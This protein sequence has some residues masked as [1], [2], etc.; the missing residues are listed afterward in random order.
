[1]VAAGVPLSGIDNLRM[2]VLQRAAWRDNPNMLHVLLAAG[3]WSTEV[4][5]SSLA[6]ALRFGNTESVR[7]LRDQGARLDWRD[8]NGET[9]L[10]EAASS[11]VPSLVREILKYHL[12]VNARDSGGWTPL[13]YAVG[14]YH[15]GEEPPPVNRAEVVILLLAAGADPN[16]QNGDGDS[17]LLNSAYNEEAA[18]AL[19]KGGRQR[20]RAK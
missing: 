14:K 12:D 16:V 13:L 11:G 15:Y 10:M 20:K 1:L 5:E 2:T 19:I 6:I 18:L 8:A 9:M 17:A 4:L 3:P 7:V